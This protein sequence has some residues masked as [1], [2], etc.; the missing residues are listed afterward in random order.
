VPLFDENELGNSSV[1]FDANAPLAARMRPRTLDEFAGQPQLVGPKAP[2]RAMLEADRLPS[3]IFYGPPGCGKT[4]LA[5]LCANLCA[6]EF[7]DFS[8][9]TGGVAQ[10]REIIARAKK[11]QQLNQRTLLFVDEIHRFNRAQQDAFL[12][13]V[14]DGTVILIGA[15][16]ENPLASLNTPLLSRCQMFRFEEL[17]ENDILQVLQQALADERGL[18]GLH[19]EVDERALHHI[20]KCSL[21]D[22]RSALNALDVA[23]DLAGATKVL[24]LELA[25]QAVKR[26]ALEYDKSG[27]NHY[28]MIS[29]YIK[30]LRGGD[31]DA[32]L[33]WM[34]RMLES[35]EDPL[36]VARRLV[37][38]SSEDVGNA[39]PRALQ[40]A[41]AAYTAVEKIGLPEAAIPLAQATIYVACSPKSNAGYMALGRAQKAVREQVPAKVP[42][43]LRSTAL[44]GS[45]ELYGN[46]TG[47][48][49]PHDFPGHFVEQQ[50]LPEGFKKEDYFQPDGMGYEKNLEQRLRQWRPARQN[51]QSEETMELNLRTYTTPD[52]AT[53]LEV[54]GEVELHNASE[55]RAQ[56]HLLCGSPK[57]HV[58]VDLSRVSFIDST[59]IGVLVGA[60]KRAR[61]AGG[62][63]IIVGARDRVHRIFEI[64]GLLGAL[65][66]AKTVEEAGQYFE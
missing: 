37:I 8:A 63:L 9:V 58:M 41:I 28:D 12:P 24:S 54:Q 26:R 39:D 33:Y 47:Y 21:G 30:S 17:T 15:T 16:T 55:L 34:A 44:R 22:A 10:V 18:A 46:G 29:A 59:G 53:V 20:A 7:E 23:A 32:A 50:Y 19:L 14:E 56:L 43:H 64:T 2:L 35:G 60:L 36:F 27:D 1:A 31:P 38:Q 4:T 42:L 52:N 25:E 57:P 3:S 66:L 11:R 13:H 6:A 45:R 65:P 62:D 5:R 61:E 48:Q 49:Y 40:I 51:H